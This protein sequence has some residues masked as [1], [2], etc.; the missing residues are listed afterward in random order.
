[1]SKI[2][3]IGLGGYSVFMTVDH[4]N[5]PGETVKADNVFAEAGGKGYNQAVAAARLGAEVA[6]V[7]AF[8]NDS[9][10]KFCVDFLDKEGIACA[11]AY[12]DV[13]S[14]YACILT[15][16]C[17]ENRVTVFGGAASKLSAE[18]VSRYESVITEADVLLLQNEVP[19]GANLCALELAKKH[20]VM[21]VFNPA[22]AA[23][24]D[25]QLLVLADI[26][27]PNE[28]EATDLFGED[29]FAGMEKAG[30]KTAVVTLGASGCAVLFNGKTFEIPAV[31]CDAVD[32]TGAGDCF[33]GALAV[34]I[35]EGMALIDAAAFATKVA[36]VA[37]GKRGAVGAM[38]HR[39]E[40]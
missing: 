3:V 16:A 1:M 40:I 31:K 28:Q 11:A 23:G 33:N 5:A 6:F 30:I 21:A 37:V 7:G 13:S 15:D 38:P 29:Y 35:S 39:N 4:F 32:T 20:G 12:K 26:I 8:G 24:L 18:D 9:E 22:P 2:C 17:G 25:K 36:S 10:G 14:A 34:G 19:I 27:T